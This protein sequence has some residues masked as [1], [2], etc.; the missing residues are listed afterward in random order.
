MERR[1]STFVDRLRGEPGIVMTRVEK[2]GAT[3]YI[4]GLRDP[5]AAEPTS[6]L[7]AAGLPIGNVAFQ[8]EEFH[9]LAPRFAGQRRLVELKD[10]LEKRAFR[11]MTGSSDIPP[12][13]LFLLEDVASQIFALTAAAT[14]LGRAVQIEVR[15]NHDP[16]GTEQTNSIL[17]RSRAENVRAALVSLGV[18]ADRLTAAAEDQE[19][20]TCSAVSEQERMF[21]RSASFRVR[22]VP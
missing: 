10:Q 8:W 19:K 18:P 22:G 20:E 21:C 7:R 6:L 13:Q 17:A 3:H 5:L 2:R 14:A 16:V 15:G 11:F 4:S 9:S 12:E 1:W